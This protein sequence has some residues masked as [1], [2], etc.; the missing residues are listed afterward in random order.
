MGACKRTLHQTNRPVELI[1]FESSRATRSGESERVTATIRHNGADVV[2]SSVGNGPIN[3]V[4]AMRTEFNLRFRLADFGQNTRSTTSK[5]EAAA[6]VELTVERD[7][8]PQSIYG[9]GSDV[10]TMA[11]IRHDKR[12]K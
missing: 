8:G 1:N 5:A 7:D 2:V 4:D 12:A 10:I 3:F 9:V 6:Y 11:P